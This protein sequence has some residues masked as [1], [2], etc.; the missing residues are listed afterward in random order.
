MTHPHEGS[1][2]STRD[3]APDLSRSALP[4]RRLLLTVHLVFAVGL[5]GA[6]LVQIGLGVAGMRG[7]AP[8]TIYPAAHLVDAWIVGPLAVVALV[9]GVVQ[10]ILTQR[11][12]FRYWW[13]TIKLTITAV[14]AVVAIFVLEPR[15]ADA[16]V[17]AQAGAVFTTGDRLPLAVAPSAAAA[18]LGVYQPGGRLRRATD[19]TA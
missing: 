5:I 3:A 9:T 4:R 7:A 14:A 15:L 13:V 16:A 11:G 6:A 12:L 2:L 8:E 1:R 17:A 19:P 18:L 10:A